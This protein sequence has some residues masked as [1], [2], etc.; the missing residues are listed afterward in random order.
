MICAKCLLPLLP[1]LPLIV[2][3][4]P[5]FRDRQ[6][7]VNKLKIIVL[8]KLWRSKVGHIKYRGMELLQFVSIYYI[9]KIKRQSDVTQFFTLQKL[10]S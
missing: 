5:K 1:L 9:K 2:K 3:V 7:I 4:M 6:E 10:G 8:G